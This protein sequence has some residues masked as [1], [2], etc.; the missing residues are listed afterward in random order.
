MLNIKVATL[1]SLLLTSFVV[2]AEQPSNSEDNSTQV[3]LDKQWQVGIGTYALVLEPDDSDY[4]EDEFTG[5]NLSLTYGAT[6]NVAIK[7]SYYDTEHDDFSQLELSGCE[8]QLL[9]GTGLAS[10]GFKIYGSFG[11]YSESMEYD[12]IDEDFSGAQLGGGIGY[13]W[14]QVALDF[15]L[16]L[17]TTSDYEDFA[18][19]D[20]ISAATSSLNIA[21]RF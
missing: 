21:Y 16:S 20:D 17:R 19:I 5:Y 12:D 4:D 15:T 3:A 11:F 9:A 6:D 8:L 2:F 7:A 13:N 18:E 14:E 10:T 1:T